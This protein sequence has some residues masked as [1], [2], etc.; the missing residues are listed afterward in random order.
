MPQ[1]SARDRGPQELPARP[2]CHNQRANVRM[3]PRAHS[4]EDIV[5]GIQS[6]ASSIA[7]LVMAGLCVSSPA[8]AGDYR[9]F[10]GAPA[11]DRT[12]RIQ[13]RVEEI[14]AADDHSRALL[15]YEKELAPAGDKYAQYMVGFM[16]LAGEG[17]AADPV[18]A[19]AWYRLAAERGEESFVEA[20]DELA[21]SLPP[22]A[23]E[24]SE[25]L[26]TELWRQYGD[27]KLLLDLV[28]DD[29]ELL[30]RQAGRI[31]ESESGSML[32]AGY[33]DQEAADPLYRRVH[34]RLLERLQYLQSRATPD[35]VGIAPDDARIRSLATQMRQV[36][37]ELESAAIR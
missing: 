27:R 1:T 37:R 34:G 23:L 26:F 30:R 10:P 20:R 24:R 3:R 28:E 8:P 15:I 21:A 9:Q 4:A 19:M 5:T 14:Y 25:E 32:A 2:C 17:V 12:L 6:R 31:A 16:H 11:D 36:Q 22:E 18:A 7:L 33:A 35:N 13:E 29:L